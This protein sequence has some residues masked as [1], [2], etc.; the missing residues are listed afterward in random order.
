ME[1]K[2]NVSKFDENFSNSDKKIKLESSIENLYDEIPESLKEIY[3]DYIENK[4]NKE[5]YKSY[6][7]KLSEIETKNEKES[8]MYY[9]ILIFCKI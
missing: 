3:N 7:E 6:Q 5:N 8:K 1:K 9:E 2:D 4:I